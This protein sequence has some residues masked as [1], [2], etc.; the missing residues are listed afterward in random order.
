MVKMTTEAQFSNNDFQDVVLHRQ[1][2]RKF[3]P[4][5]KIE[6]AELQAMIDEATSAP[7]ACNLQSWHFVVAAS[8]AGKAKAKQLLM[9]F[10]YPQVETCSVMIFILGDT[11]SHLVYRDV[12]NKACEDGRISAE[13][14]DQIFKTFLPLYENAS[15]AFLKMDATIDSSMAAMQLLLV[16]RAHGYDANPIAGYAADKVAVTFDL[17]PQRYVPVMAVAIGKAAAEPITTTRY[18]GTEVTEFI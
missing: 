16:A 13:K 15:P 7:S 11:E 1:S 17:D 12:W 18:A 6:L 2:V 8:D 5:V 3:D 14:R 9:P 4:T 10:N